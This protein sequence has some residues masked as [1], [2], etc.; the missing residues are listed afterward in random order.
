MASET[1][2]ERIQR[3]RAEY[4][5]YLETTTDD[6]KMSMPEWASAQHSAKIAA[7]PAPAEITAPAAAKP[8]P[9]AAP[10]KFVDRVWAGGD[11]DSDDIYFK[12]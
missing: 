3:Q 1:K 9:V 8:A 4:A 6:P 10:R 11:R 2:W 5:A 7:T 12:R